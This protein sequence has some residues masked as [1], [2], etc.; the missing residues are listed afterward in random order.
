M[1]LQEFTQLKH[2]THEVELLLCEVEEAVSKNGGTY[3]R[4]GFQD[5]TA[6]LKAMLFGNEEMARARQLLHRAVT[7]SLK[8]E[9]DYPPKVVSL[10]PLDRPENEF[11]RVSA[12]A[13]D[14][15]GSTK[16]LA[17]I[18]ERLQSAHAKRLYDAFTSEKWVGLMAKHAA[19]SRVH[20]AYR[21]GFLEHVLG[22]MENY[23]CL[24]DAGRYPELNSDVVYLGLLLHDIGKLMELKETSPGVF[25][26]TRKGH[27]HGH[28]TMGYRIC[29]E[30]AKD[31]AQREG[32]D[33]DKSD[34]VDEVLH[35][36][37][38]HHGQLP[39]GSPVTPK[40][41]E[42]LM[43][44]LLDSMDAKLAIARETPHGDRAFHLEK[45]VIYH[46]PG[47]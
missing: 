22:L 37:L 4:L 40:T 3:M 10:A 5:K 8:V 47:E 27:T 25:T 31:S 43:V 30:A 39:F 24:H 20:H 15:E 14:I 7:A 34:F 23:A 29:Y 28:I 13:E 19:S 12:E 44:H 46:E 18:R 26:Y 16:R 6:Q 32:D 9:S 1:N 38:A 45:S 21:G 33:F 11:L 2:G 35:V 42:A 41:P 36:I 17:A